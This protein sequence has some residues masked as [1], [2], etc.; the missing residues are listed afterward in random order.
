MKMTDMTTNIITA[1]FER[2]RKTVD[3]SLA[4]GMESVT[5]AAVLLAE[6]AKQNRKLLVC[7]NGGSAADAQHLASEWVCRY[8]GDRRPLGAV[9]L[10]TDTSALTAI[11]NDYG[12]EEI[13]S[14]QVKALGAPGDVFIGI[15]TSG[16]SKNILAALRTA[17]TMKLATI[18]LTGEGGSALEGGA[19]IVI[20]VPSLETARIQELH[21]L[22]IHAWCEYVDVSLLKT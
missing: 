14:R 3:V 20:A 19:D 12:F 21:E 7:G 8:K 11:G 13:F 10:T 6:A 22:I 1:A 4:A 15:T 9:A 18:V 16:K 17:R 5:R 2:H